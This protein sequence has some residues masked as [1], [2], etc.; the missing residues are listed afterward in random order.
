MIVNNDACAWAPV[1]AS[2]VC[3]GSWVRGL[4]VV[5][6]ES[7]TPPQAGAA[8][9]VAGCGDNSLTVWQQVGD[10]L[11]YRGGVDVGAGVRAVATR[12]A[13]IATGSNEGGVRTWALAATNSGSVEIVPQR[14]LTPTCDKG[15][16]V[17]CV[18]W[19][20][21]GRYLAAGS[22]AGL[23]AIHT[24]LEEDVPSPLLFR[25]HSGSVNAVAWSPDGEL[26][27]SAGHDRDVVLANTSK[28]AI[29]ARMQHRAVVMG[30][31]WTPSSAR[32]LATLSDHSIVVWNTTNA[33]HPV[34]LQCFSPHAATTWC[35][36][37]C[38]PYVATGGADAA[39]CVSRFTTDACTTL[40]RV[41]ELSGHTGSVN[42]VAWTPDGAL[43]SVSSD[44][45]MRLWS[46]NAGR[47]RRI[48]PLARSDVAATH[49]RFDANATAARVVWEDQ[50]VD[51]VSLTGDDVAPNVVFSDTATAYPACVGAVRVNHALYAIL[52]SAKVAPLNDKTQ[53]R[54][55][56]QIWEAPG[57]VHETEVE[58]LRRKL[59]VLT[60]R[61]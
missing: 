4:G 7:L 61:Q 24:D 58:S 11:E 17:W 2:P 31:A 14:T 22:E 32:L 21:D 46:R 42:A 54:T 5:R 60:G 36:A 25:A 20:V 3:F 13:A 44:R 45:S 59:A 39:V 19:S 51:I 6:G 15:D 29:I 16:I 53:W 23:V 55:R 40:V 18:A 41:A 26:L 8:F 56:L 38:L 12:G 34:R 57:C 43:V 49:V 1:W 27:A 30:L 28:H 35:A 37:V 48:I 10:T 52:T 50:T 33:A 9:Y 47:L